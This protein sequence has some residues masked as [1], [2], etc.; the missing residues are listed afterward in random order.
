LAVAIIKAVIALSRAR[1]FTKYLAPTLFVFWVVL[2][3]V[4]FEQEHLADLAHGR[5]A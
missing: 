3:L 4:I 2:D 1:L 5:E